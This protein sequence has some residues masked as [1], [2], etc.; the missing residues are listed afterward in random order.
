MS[1]GKLF[2][3]IFIII[4]HI[5][6]S[7]SDDEKPIDT[8]F[9]SITRGSFI[10]TLSLSNTD[11][12]IGDTSAI[13][14]LNLEEQDERNGELLENIEVYIQFIDNTIDS[15]DISTEEILVKTLNL[16]DFSIGPDNLP[17][18]TLNLGYQELIETLNINAPAISCKDQILVRL[19]LNL[20]DGRTFTSEDSSNTSSIIALDTFSSSPFCYTINLVDP[21]PSKDQ[22]TGIYRYTSII[23]GPFGP[24]F[25]ESDVVEIVKGTSEN[26]RVF[27]AD[28]I[29]SRR[30]EA[31]R[32]F[33]FVVTCD[34]IR[35]DKNQ[36]SSFFSWCRPSGATSFGGPPVLLGPDTQ[37]STINPNDDVT[38]DLLFVEGFEGWDG[39]CGFGTVPVQV[40]FTKQ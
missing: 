7:C 17:R 13:F 39:D 24:T 11:F 10:R 30:N 25:G 37:N 8:V 3:F 34:E 29:V 12:I 15:E 16:N 14:S 26:S 19:A 38:F 40:R 27:Y 36:L 6:I 31:S 35:F 22:F 1:K 2:C 23:D 5:H 9:E 20:N 32:P 33:R 21:L 4:T 28:Y 18:T